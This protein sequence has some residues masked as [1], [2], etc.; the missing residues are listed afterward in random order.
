MSTALRLVREYPELDVLT[1][2]M[3]AA[4]LGTETDADI[5]G[6]EAAEPEEQAQ[7]P[8]SSSGGAATVTDGV[9]E[10]GE[11]DEATDNI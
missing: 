3:S 4:Y 7:E 2:D 8:S 1:L 5:N 9:D 6:D 11:I 10:E